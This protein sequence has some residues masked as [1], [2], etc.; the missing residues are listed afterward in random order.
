MTIDLQELF[1][2]VKGKDEK[3]IYALLKA[4]KDK[5]DPAVFDYFKFKQSVSALEKLDMDTSTSYKS[6]FTTA[7]TMGLTKDKLVRSASNYVNVLDQERESFATALIARKKERVDGRKEEVAGY[8]KKIEEHKN[9]ILELQREIE[10][11][12]SRIDNV[13]QDVEAETL[14]IEGTKDK[15][16]DVYNL[17]TAAIKKDI[18]SINNY[19]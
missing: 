2:S 18:E 9:K 19:L 1:P 7:A 12:Q 13:D 8:V 17:I 6:A 16:L 10:I 11:F 3:S 4:M 14:K 5:Y 15:F